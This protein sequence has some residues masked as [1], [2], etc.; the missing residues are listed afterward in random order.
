MISV[1]RLV[2]TSAVTFVGNMRLY[3]SV[4]VVG[5]VT[6]VAFGCSHPQQTTTVITPPPST[7]KAPVEGSATDNSASKTP[8]KSSIV[9][10][11]E[12][13]AKTDHVFPAG[14]QVKSVTLEDGVVS[15][16]FSHEFSEL[17]NSGETV[18]SDA[19]HSLRKALSKFTTIEKMRVTVEGKPFESQATD[20]NT[21]F[22]VRDAASAN[23][24]K[25]NRVGSESASR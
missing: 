22:L 24:G 5:A 2:I 17:A 3:I 11:L 21:P 23:P 1:K 14:V 16:D 6:L 7:P 4:V 25:P 8:V 19:Q 13:D 20:W 10:L 18:E 15:I 12:Q 9:A